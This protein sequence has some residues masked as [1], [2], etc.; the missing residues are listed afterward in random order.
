MSEFQAQLKSER[1]RR[2]GVE[3]GVFNAVGWFTK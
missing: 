3:V 2:D 1:A